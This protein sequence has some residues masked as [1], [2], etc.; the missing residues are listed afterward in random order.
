[1]AVGSILSFYTMSM[2]EI[3]QHNRPTSSQK[4]QPLPDP[5]IPLMLPILCKS[6]KCVAGLTLDGAL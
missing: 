6:E 5:T 3:L 1:M 2:K 4:Q